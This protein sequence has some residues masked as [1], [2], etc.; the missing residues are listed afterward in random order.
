MTEK[1][2]ADIV[3]EHPASAAIFRA[4][5]IDFCCNGDRTL[6][7]ACA[8]RGLDPRT[9]AAAIEEELARRAD[10]AAEEDVRALST[11]ALLER[12]VDRHHGF[13]RRLLPAL[14]PLAVK[15][16]R[17]HGDKDERL[18]ELSVVLMRLRDAL[19]PH[20]DD[21]EERLFPN[22]LAPEGKEERIA[23]ALALMVREHREVGEMLGEMRRLTD[24]F[25][26]PPWGCTSYRTLFAE[27]AEL[28]A[29]LLRHIHLENHAVLPRFAPAN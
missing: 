28:E 27:L 4:N 16:A 19:E 9:I 10:A 29:D 15:V 7:E 24:D 2:I 5:R 26:P 11:E 25:V 8:E 17:V 13:L 6:A 22:L 20:L 12:I 1:T 21:E 18:R 3:L 14:V 23:K